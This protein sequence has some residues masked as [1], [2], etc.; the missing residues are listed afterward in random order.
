MFIAF[1]GPD[2]TGK[3]T[4]AAHLSHDGRAIYN[5]TTD[6][7]KMLKRFM[8]DMTDL[9]VAYDRI[10]WLTHMVYRL[11]LPG[12]EWNDERPRTV[13]PMPDTHLVFK[14]HDPFVA[15][16]IDDE[17]YVTGKVA[18]AN[19]MYRAQAS[20]LTRLNED[21]DYSL[22]KTISMVEVYNDLKTGQF[23]QSLVA[24]SSP[25]TEA[26]EALSRKV[27]NDDKLLALLRDEDQQRL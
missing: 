12:H 9:V 18:A 23:Y 22:F 21:M 10:D 24:Y 20:F 2:K 19:R 16:A 6:K 5:V 14:L 25:V 13:F 27:D 7:H 8:G 1:E 3:S 17:L 15:E 11:A 26:N 4:S